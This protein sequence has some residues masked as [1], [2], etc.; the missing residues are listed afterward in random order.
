[1]PMFRR[2]LVLSSLM[3]VL[4][5]CGGTLL[6]H[7]YSVEG[8]G[9]SAVLAPGEEM[10][11]ARPLASVKFFFYPY[12]SDSVIHPVPEREFVTDSLGRADFAEKATPGDKM[13][14]L[15]GMKPGYFLDTLVFRY[16]ADDTLDIVVRLR[17]R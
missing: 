3:A 13:G 14:A 12:V 2:I 5:G 8:E 10:P 6:M 11:A 17:R 9:R 15:V 16:S 4:S 1:M 7:V